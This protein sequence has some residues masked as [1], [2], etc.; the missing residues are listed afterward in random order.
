MPRK[1]MRFHPTSKPL[2]ACIIAATHDVL[3]ANLLT[4]SCRVTH[5]KD[6]SFRLVVKVIGGVQ[7][8]FAATAGDT[9]MDVRQFLSEVAAPSACC[10][11]PHTPGRLAST[12]RGRG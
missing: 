4:G 10:S 11:R 1:S 3:T 9:I 7:L 6:V 2:R 12:S 5:Q 8:T